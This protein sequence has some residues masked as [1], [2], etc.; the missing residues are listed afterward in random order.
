MVVLAEAN[1]YPDSMRINSCSPRDGR[2]ED[3]QCKQLAIVVV[4]WGVV[5]FGNHWEALAC[6]IGTLGTQ[7]WQ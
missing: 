7:Q 5:P 3:I 2:L 6:V 1:L 4:F